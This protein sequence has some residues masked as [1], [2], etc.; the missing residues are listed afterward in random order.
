MS[1]YTRSSINFLR[2]K[3][4]VSLDFIHSS[5][6]NEIENG[7]QETAK[8]VIFSKKAICI[9][10]AQIKKKELYRQIKINNFKEYLKRKRIPFNYSTALDYSIIGE[11]FLKYK[12]EL[13]SVHFNEEDGLQ[14]LLLLEKGL[15]NNKEHPQYVF[16]KIREDSFRD[17]KLFV[18]NN[19]RKESKQ[20]LRKKIFNLQDI[21]IKIEDETVSLFPEGIDILWFNRDIENRLGMPGIYKKFQKHIIESVNNFFQQHFH[22]NSIK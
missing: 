12:N 6:L 2:K 8:G 7:I 17:F 18:N 15:K 1:N 13:E 9:A 16:R 10:L 5:T 4:A 3:L 22:N 14:K 11:M 19:G 20:T 21:S